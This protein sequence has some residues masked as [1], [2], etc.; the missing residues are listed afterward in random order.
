MQESPADNIVSLAHFGVSNRKAKS[1]LQEALK[2]LVR[3]TNK[4]KFTYGQLKY[5]F[6]EVRQ[7]C[8]VH[9][10]RNAKRLV[11]LPTPNEL[12]AFYNVIRNPVHRLIFETLH[13]TGLRVAE[14]CSLQVKRLDLD[15]NTAFI[16]QG[17]GS[18]DRI[19]VIGNGLKEKLAIYL[20]GKN[21]KFVFESSRNTQF[22]TRRIEQLC[23]RYKLAAGIERD[24]TPHTFRHL[25][26]TALAE[27]GVSKERRM[28]LA[29][30]SS[31]KTQEIYTHLGLGGF[32]QDIV[33]VLDLGHAGK[34]N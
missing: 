7:I 23:K 3:A 25:W 1:E 33:K 30:H 31:E 21:H 13:G 9:P 34:P 10:D 16:F 24:L 19:V 4:N 2:A 32:K 15:S 22:S 28:I 8:E 12:V 11:Q 14:L 27:A 17:K 18:K 5:L 29:G 6:K 26:N 20:E